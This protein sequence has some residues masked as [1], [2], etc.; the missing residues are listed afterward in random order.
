MITIAKTTEGNTQD[1]N[2][3]ILEIRGLSTD[4]KPTENITNGS[5]FIE[6]NTGKIYFYNAES[7]QWI[8]FTA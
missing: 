2:N 1:R 4:N 7:E 8:E 3:P 5:S 6:M